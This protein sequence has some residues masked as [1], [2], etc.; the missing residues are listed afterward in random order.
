MGCWPRY[1]EAVTQSVSTA[2]LSSPRAGS[3][4]WREDPPPS[5]SRPWELHPYM[6][7]SGGHPGCGTGGACGLAAPTS[8][9]GREKPLLALRRTLVMQS[10]F[11]KP[12]VGAPPRPPSTWGLA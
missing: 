3:A 8:P 6:G 4:T 7:R 9:H 11:R 12:Q 1:S 2:R 10:C 5:R